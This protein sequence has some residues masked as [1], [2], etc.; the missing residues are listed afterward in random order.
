[1]KKT[2]ISG[3]D[4]S[5]GFTW[6]P[7]GVTLRDY[8]AGQALSGFIAGLLANGSKDAQTEFLADA[9]YIAAD[10]MLKAREK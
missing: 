6:T 3:S 2:S 10:D 8:F 7:I 9:A 5:I 4:F 1:M